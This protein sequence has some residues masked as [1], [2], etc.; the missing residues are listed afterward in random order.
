[1]V[2]DIVV[3]QRHAVEQAWPSPTRGSWPP[4]RAHR[5][6]LSHAQARIARHTLLVP[7]LILAGDDYAV[8]APGQ[9]APVPPDNRVRVRRQRQCAHDRLR[10]RRR[11]L[12]HLRCRQA[13]AR[14]DQPALWAR[15]APTRMTRLAACCPL[16][17]RPGMPQTPPSVRST[18]AGLR[19]AVLH[20]MLVSEMR[21]T[22]RRSIPGGDCREPTPPHQVLRVPREH[23]IVVVRCSHREP[24]RSTLTTA[25]AS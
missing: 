15:C 24:Q 1:M 5:R 25:A 11:Q 7:Y 19:S 23:R 22:T 6:S 13:P 10:Q 2:S 14:R 18:S 3:D 4:K 9:G 17:T 21:S 20:G 16:R 12:R 8:R